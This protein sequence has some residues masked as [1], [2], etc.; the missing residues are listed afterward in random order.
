M[1]IHKR[2]Q[3]TGESYGK[4]NDDSYSKNDNQY[5][6][7]KATLISFSRL[8]VKRLPSSFGKIERQEQ[9][10][11]TEVAHAFKSCVNN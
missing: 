1:V 10:T 4:K 5:A 2:I 7:C 3:T 11:K 9:G 8:M 6:T